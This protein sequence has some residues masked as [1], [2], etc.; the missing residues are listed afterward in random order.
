[1]IGPF[2]FS[3]S[4]AEALTHFGSM[5]WYFALTCSTKKLENRMASKIQ[6]AHF[7]CWK[8]LWRFL[9]QV[10]FIVSATNRRSQ[11]IQ[12]YSWPGQ[13]GWSLCNLHDCEFLEFILQMVQD[14]NMG[15]TPHPMQLNVSKPAGK[16]WNDLFQVDSW[17]YELVICVFFYSWC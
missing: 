10:F 1:M 4:G 16:V 9:M 14:T 15:M 6:N 13:S 3:W 8:P 11:S 12:V 17:K 5:M 2:I 7:V